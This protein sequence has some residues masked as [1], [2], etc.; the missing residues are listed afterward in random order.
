M[1]VVPVAL[2]VTI[3]IVGVGGV[4]KLSLA[5]LRLERPAVVL[6]VSVQSYQLQ[7]QSEAGSILVVSTGDQFR[8]ALL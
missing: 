5:P 7:H 6:Q 4:L 8:P 1:V 3:L 2:D